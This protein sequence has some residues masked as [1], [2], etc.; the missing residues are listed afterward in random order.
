MLYEVITDRCGHSGHCRDG[1]L[2]RRDA[3]GRIAVLFQECSEIAMTPSLSIVP[4]AK[5]VAASPAL[6]ISYNFV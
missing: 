2:E 3:Q 6:E 1:T 5:A 4:A